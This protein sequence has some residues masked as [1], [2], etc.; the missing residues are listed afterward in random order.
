MLEAAGVTGRRKLAR[1][2]CWGGAPGSAGR[3]TVAPCREASVGMAEA[4]QGRCG[5]FSGNEGRVAQGFGCGRSYSR[6]CGRAGGAGWDS[7]SS[8]RRGRCK[9]AVPVSRFRSDEVL[10]VG[11]RRAVVMQGRSGSGG[12]ASDRFG[13]TVIWPCGGGF[14]ELFVTG[15][16]PYGSEEGA[17]TRGAARIGKRKAAE[18]SAASGTLAGNRTRICGLGNRRSIR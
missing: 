12:P 16:A 3:G 17:G 4:M 2:G 14:S 15:S 9:G 11:M 1:G 6:S 13:H 8:G 10:R 18:F 5:V 7:G